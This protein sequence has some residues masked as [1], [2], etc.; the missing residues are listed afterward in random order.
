MNLFDSQAASA[1]RKAAFHCGLNHTD[2]QSLSPELRACLH[3]CTQHLTQLLLYDAS[4]PL[5][6]AA[7]LPLAFG[8]AFTRGIE[9]ALLWQAERL[10]DLEPLAAVELWRGHRRGLGDASLD[11]LLENAYP[12]GTLFFAAFADWATNSEDAYCASYFEEELASSLFFTSFI[13]ASLVLRQKTEPQW[14]H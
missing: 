4:R 11:A 9:G 6:L 14:L 5:P 10:D 7:A 1:L 2:I 8:Y 12:G 3:R 13:G